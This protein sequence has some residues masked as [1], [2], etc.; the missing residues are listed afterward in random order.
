MQAEETMAPAMSLEQRQTSYSD[1][2]FVLRCLTA[3]NSFAVCRRGC[4]KHGLREVVEP[5]PV[6]DASLG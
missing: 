4:V 3:Y 1:V 5:E 2:S 6:E